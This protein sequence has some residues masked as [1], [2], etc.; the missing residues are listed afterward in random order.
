MHYQQD[1]TPQFPT[2]HEGTVLS[3]LESDRGLKVHE[4]HFVPAIPEYPS[5]SRLG[6]AYV[7]HTA[8]MSDEEVELQKQ[9]VRIY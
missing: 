3:A 4:L 6:V 1:I 9:A 8:G 2:E 5:T 7:V